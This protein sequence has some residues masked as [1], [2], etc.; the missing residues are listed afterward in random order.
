[1]EK[2]EIENFVKNQNVKT[3]LQKVVGE[4]AHIEVNYLNLVKKLM[5]KI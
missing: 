1:M 3:T 5:L 2:L 4:F